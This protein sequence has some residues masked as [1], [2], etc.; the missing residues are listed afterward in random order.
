MT[1]LQSTPAPLSAG[2]RKEAV[3]L[4]YA[5]G[6]DDV[7]SALAEAPEVLGFTVLIEEDVDDSKPN[8][9]RASR[10]LHVLQLPD[11]STFH[12]LVQGLATA[13]TFGDEGEAVEWVVVTEYDLTRPDVL[14]AVRR[15]T[16]LD[17][18]VSV[19]EPHAA[20]NTWGH[21][22]RPAPNTGEAL[23]NLNHQLAAAVIAWVEAVRD[24]RDLDPRPLLPPR[25]EL[26]EL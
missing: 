6:R 20:D 22:A 13:A 24:L 23:T 15:V 8:A 18:T 9:V 12:V 1:D 21:G 19:L 25:A 5:A 26:M 11:G 3:E 14:A 4:A 2:Q 16:G 10:E 17:P 7:G